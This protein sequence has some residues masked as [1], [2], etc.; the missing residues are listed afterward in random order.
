MKNKLLKRFFII[1][2]PLLFVFYL[3]SCGE[4]E[5][6]EPHAIEPINKSYTVTFDSDGGNEIN[7]VTVK[8]NEKV[9][10]PSNPKKD[11]Y[12]FLGWYLGDTAFDFNTE[13]KND[14]TLKAKWRNNSTVSLSRIDAN[15]SYDV[16]TK[17]DDSYFDTPSNV[18]SKDLVRFAF[19]MAAINLG[20]ERVIN[21]FQALG[22]DN[23]YMIRDDDSNYD[24]ISYSF[25]HK[26]I[27]NNDLIAISIRGMR[28]Y[29]EWAGNFDLGNTGNHKDFDKCAGNV[30]RDLIK[31]FNDNN[32]SSSSKIIISGYSRSAAISNLLADKMM[33][34]TNKLVE[35]NNLYVYTF[36]TPKGILKENATA[37]P[38]VFNIVNSADIVTYLAPDEFE[39]T[40][41]GIDIDIYD[42]NVSTILKEFDSSFILPEYKNILGN[43]VKGDLELPSAIIKALLNYHA[44]S[45]PETYLEDLEYEIDTREKFDK[46]MS[47]IIQYLFDMAFGTNTSTLNKMMQGIMNIFNKDISEAINIFT[48]GN[49]L[50]DFVKCYLEGDNISYDDEMLTKTSDKLVGALLRNTNLLLFLYLN[51]PNFGRMASMHS[52][53]VCYLLLENYLKNN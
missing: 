10:I 12:S 42:P 6:E 11:K 51:S 27:G 15:V 39:F 46:N 48:H 37:Y 53:P 35:D 45:E 28:Y 44:N 47:P 52:S 4:N 38:N 50:H 9:S 20:D 43:S 22:F 25:A 19:N 34:D 40:R 23:M 26:K 3:S 41:C 32:Y 2:M 7:P 17:F 30:Y 8:E 29:E 13:I 16:E 49:L 14:I 1:S 24:G 21:F 36:E 18:F 33:R 31:Y 5:I